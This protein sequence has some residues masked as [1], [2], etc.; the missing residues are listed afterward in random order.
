M[1]AI[2]WWCLGDVLTVCNERSNPCS[3]PYDSLSPPSVASFLPMDD[4]GRRSGAY[5]S[6]EGQGGEDT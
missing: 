4:H 6:A 2:E 3:H 1:T 5:V